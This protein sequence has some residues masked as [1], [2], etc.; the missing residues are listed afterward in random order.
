M[1]TQAKKNTKQKE[2]IIES[3]NEELTKEKVEDISEEQVDAYKEKIEQENAQ[4]REELEKQKQANEDFKK[5]FEQMQAQML[6][7]TKAMTQNVGGAQTTTEDDDEMVEVCCRVF[8]GLGMTNNAG[9]SQINFKCGESKFISASDLK[10]FLKEGIRNNKAL[11][12]KSLL[13][14]TNEENYN[15]F[16]IRKI[17][18]LSEENVLN[19]IQTKNTNEMIRKVNTLTNNL[20]DDAVLYTFKFMIAD[21]LMNNKLGGWSYES[22]D[23]LEK[24]LGVKFDVLISNAGMYKQFK[25]IK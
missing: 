21:M 24:H 2:E 15:K 7:L 16:K 3:I 22:R 20:Y 25:N 9:T 13:F 23:A 17:V 18:D 14:F 4:L 12:A 1:A 11:F 10:D 6:L 8:S 19:I 5:Q